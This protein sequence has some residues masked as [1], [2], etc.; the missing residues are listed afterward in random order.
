MTRRAYRR[1]R[2]DLDLGLAPPVE[3]PGGCLLLQGYAAGPGVYVY[4]EDDGSIRREYVPVT[5]LWHAD[6]VEGL[7]RA[8]VTLGHPPV[9]VDGTNFRQYVHGD[10]GDVERGPGDK[11][12]I[13]DL[14]ARTAEIRAAISDPEDPVVELSPGY[15]VDLDETPGVTPEGE[16]YDAVQVRR[17][18]NHLAVVT[19]ARGGPEM[20]LRVDDQSDSAIMQSSI[21]LDGDQPSAETPMRRKR[22]DEPAEHEK[23][24]SEQDAAEGSEESEDA[25]AEQESEDAAGSEEEPQVDVLAALGEKIDALGKYMDALAKLDDLMG[26]LDAFLGKSDEAEESEDEGGEADP[27][28][29]DARSDGDDVE[30]RVARRVNLLR[31]A[32]RVNLRV[33]SKGVTDVEIAKKIADAAGFSVAHCR[34]DG[35]VFA[36]VEALG[37]LDLRDPGKSDTEIE[38]GELAPT[39]S[40]YGPRRAK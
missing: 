31:T 11:V 22:T 25:G 21:P 39:P 19:R 20:R 17:E 9:F 14:A 4:V 6:A 10:V 37:N 7:R 2:F 35:E 8:P 3:G 18:Y 15:F 13:L 26:K 28:N 5:T 27:K 12:K 38:T 36:V 1:D 29:E 32:E 33:D 16:E 34:T 24:A 40:P 30:A 23:P